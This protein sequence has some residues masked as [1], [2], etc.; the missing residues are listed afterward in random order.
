MSV[1]K[2]SRGPSVSMMSMSAW[3][4][5]VDVNMNASTPSEHST[6]DAGLDS[7]Y[8]LMEIHV[9][10]SMNVPLPMEDARIDV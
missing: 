4:T 9:L 6:V 5:M 7:S 3:L 10:T 2:D 8:L 1:H